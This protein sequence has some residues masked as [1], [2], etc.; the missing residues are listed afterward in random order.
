MIKVQQLAREFQ[1]LQ[2]TTE[3][4]TEITSMF[5]EKPL[6]VLQYVADE[7]MNK[8][9]YHEM[10]QSNIR[11]FVCRSSCKTL[12]DMIKRAQERELTL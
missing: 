3:T 5:R 8:A 7:E 12:E 4:V 1:D 10:L 6:I 2:Q 11:Q 9:R